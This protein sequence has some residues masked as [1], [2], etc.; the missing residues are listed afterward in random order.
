MRA[1]WGAGYVVPYVALQCGQL[2]NGP[3]GVGPVD[4]FGKIKRRSQRI[5]TQD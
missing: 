2:G 1:E 4:I 3:D 5:S